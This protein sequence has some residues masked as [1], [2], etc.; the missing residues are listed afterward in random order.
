[1]SNADY[2]WLVDTVCELLEG[3]DHKALDYDIGAIAE[4]IEDYAPTIH[5]REDFDDFVEDYKL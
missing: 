3:T 5:S 2:D 1:M 4:D